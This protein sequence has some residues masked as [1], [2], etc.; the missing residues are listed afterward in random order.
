MGLEFAIAKTTAMV[1]SR[2][3][4]PAILSQPLLMNGSEVEVV[5]DFKCLGVTLDHQLRWRI[6][7]KN[8]IAKAKKHL[9]FL[10]KGLGTTWGPTPAI[11]LWLYTCIVRP[12]LTYGAAVWSVATH[13]KGIV[14][15]LKK[16]QRLGMLMVAPVRRKTPTSG[17]EVTLGVPPLHLYI[18]N[19]ATST[20]ARLD[21][22][23]K[24][25]RGQT[26]Q[27]K[28]GHIKRLENSSQCLPHRNMLDRCF[29]RNLQNS[30]YTFI[31][32]GEDT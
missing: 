9:M 11:T 13:K 20:Y 8:K 23:P 28:P 2:R 16:V 29:C 17:L 21:L 1:F 24:G 22:A 32:K 12:A 4:S 26:G 7:I 19:L 14:K 3:R 10:H 27:S 5:Q 6:H 31:G 30:F 25:W 15:E 18:Q